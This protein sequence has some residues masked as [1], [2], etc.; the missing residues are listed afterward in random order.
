MMLLDIARQNLWV[1]LALWVLIYVSDYTLTLVGA[2]AAAKR[3]PNVSVQG[4]YE[5]N[6][7]FVNDVNKRRRIS[8]RF[9]LALVLTTVLLALLWY[10]SRSSALTG[11]LFEVAFGALLLVEL[12]IHVRHLRNILSYRRAT[13]PGEVEGSIQFSR[14]YA[15]WVSALDLAVF[16]L[17]YLILFLLVGRWFFVGGFIACASLALR[18][19]LRMNKEPLLTA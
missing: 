8:P 18:H 2:Q 15:Y 13:Q 3:A 16:A 1:T 11:V 9:L 4:S 19:R 12:A 6:P 10:L 17:F 7:Y 5:L 14:R